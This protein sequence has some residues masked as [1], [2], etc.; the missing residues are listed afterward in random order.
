M[1]TVPLNQMADTTQ[2]H[3]AGADAKAGVAFVAR[4]EH[5]PCRFFNGRCMD[6]GR[7]YGEPRT[8]GVDGMTPILSA[9]TGVSQ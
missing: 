4:G 8:D 3:L 9:A 5:H 6:C 1:Q 2:D 7:A